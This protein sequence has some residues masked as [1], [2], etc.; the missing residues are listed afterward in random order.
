MSSVWGSGGARR[1]GGGDRDRSRNSRRNLVNSF[2]YVRALV[3]RQPRQAHGA[4]REVN[5][6]GGGGGAAARTGRG[7]AG[8]AAVTRRSHAGGS[9][10][11][12]SHTNYVQLWQERVR[13]N[14]ALYRLI[15]AIIV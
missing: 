2:S 9:C 10:C 7:G 4:A 15:S 8:V 5:D 1:R 13:I 6:P 3:P 12:T 14:R 11:A